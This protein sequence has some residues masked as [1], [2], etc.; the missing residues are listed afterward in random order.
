[1]SSRDAIPA[2]LKPLADDCHVMHGG[3]PATELLQAL[4]S[5]LDQPTAWRTRVRP[6]RAVLRSRP[7]GRLPVKA[8]K[9]AS[10]RMSPLRFCAS[11]RELRT[12]R[13]FGSRVLTRV[14]AVLGAG[15]PGVNFLVLQKVAGATELEGYLQREPDRL[16]DDVKLQR[17]W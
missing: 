13:W 5:A 17:Q 4:V 8:T 16:R 11:G 3:V 6:G 14:H 12:L 9:R 10:W 2:L 7:A 1:M 15:K